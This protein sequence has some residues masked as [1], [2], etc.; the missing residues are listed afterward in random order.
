MKNSDYILYLDLDG[1]LVDYSSG[2]WAIAKQLGI[3]PV[4]VKGELEYTK[5]DISRVH[6]QTRNPKFWGS[7]GWEHG[8]EE[9]WGA[10][11]IL[12]ENIHIL[13]STAT[14]KD[15][16]AHKIVEEGKFEWL[17]ENLHPHLPPSNIHV[18]SEGVQ[19]ANFANHLSILVDDRK[20]TIKAFIQAGGYGVL[21]DAK[22][23]RKTIEELKE[24]TL[25][26]GLGEIARSLPIVRRGFWNRK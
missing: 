6:A 11:N 2:W 18:V 17:K 16:Q 23:Y 24:V 20:S 19:K 26:L 3:K 4:S 15:I 12:F 10:A 8:G 1:V 9:L 7:L 14:K 21:H 5:E 22:K 25:P 13:T